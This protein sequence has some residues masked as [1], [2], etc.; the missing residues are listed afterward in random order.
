MHVIIR[1]L[2]REIRTVATVPSGAL[3]IVTAKALEPFC[4]KPLEELKAKAT[5]EE[6]AGS[7]MD[8]WTEREPR[9]SSGSVASTETVTLPDTVAAGS[10]LRVA[11]DG[12]S[13]TLSTVTERARVEVLVVRGVGRTI[14]RQTA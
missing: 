1:V 5:G 6:K 8:N 12:G 10:G 9:A 7:S 2:V 3:D 14:H 13:S 4:I 11:A